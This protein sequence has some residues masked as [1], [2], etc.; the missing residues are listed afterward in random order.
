M[1][2]TQML[3]C[4]QSIKTDVADDIAACHLFFWVSL[5]VEGIA[6]HSKDGTDA[7]ICMNATIVR[8]I[9]KDTH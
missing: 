1:Y 6:C 2:D 7:V 8:F 3:I 9:K 4:A 5:M